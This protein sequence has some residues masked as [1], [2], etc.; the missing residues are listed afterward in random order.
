MPAFT[1]VFLVFMYWITRQTY[2]A[3]RTGIQWTLTRK[4]E[5]LNF[6]DDLC[7][8]SHKL[9]HM[10]AKLEA[11]QNTSG[12]VGLKINTEK[13]QEM[14]IQAGDVMPIRIGKEDIKRMYHFTYLS[15]IVLSVTGGT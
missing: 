14:R 9:Q 8:M 15:R 13:T 2:G 3:G 12:R 4:L 5:D 7:L 10:R 1:V 11:L 6:A